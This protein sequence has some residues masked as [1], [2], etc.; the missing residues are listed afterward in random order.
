MEKRQEKK[1]NRLHNVAVVL[2]V[3]IVLSAGIVATLLVINLK[4]SQEETI[5]TL[6]QTIDQ[7]YSQE[8]VQSMMAGAVEDASSSAAQTTKEEILG[9]IK[10]EL[11]AGKSTVSVLRP[12]YPEELVLASNGAYH[13]IPIRDDLAKHSLTAENLV[14]AEN[15]QIS[16][17]EGGNI[18]SYKGIDVSKY[19]QNI[20]WN[21]VKADGV[22]YAFIRVGLRGYGTGEINLDEQFESHIQGAQAAGIDTGVYFFSQA[23]TVAEAIEEADFVLEQIAPYNITYP[24][25]FDIEKVASSSGRM[26]QLTSEERTNVTL[27]FCQRIEEAGYTPM[28]YGNLE[29]FG[30]LMDIGP[31]EKYEKWFAF[32]DPSIYYPYDFKIWQYTD[33]GTVD[34]IDGEVDLNISFKKW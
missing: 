21:K 22:D 7:M 15:G 28:I 30:L 1:Y 27:A 20:D 16:Y 3:L 17:T 2:G 18:I 8:D 33:K 12:L 5:Q 13:F 32:Y 10:A 19:Q 34:G 6:S 25:V 14:V 29:M 4:K 23:I 31:L 11:A 26:N 24:V 9:G